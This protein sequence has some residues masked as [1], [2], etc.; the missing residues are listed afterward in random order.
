M[1]PDPFPADQNFFMPAEW[2]T[3]SATWLTW[4]HN[5]ETWPGTDMQAIEAVYL[6]MIRALSEGET[7]HVLLQD[8]AAFNRVHSQLENSRVSI[9]R[10]HCHLIP[11]NDSWI[12]DYGPNFLVRRDTGEVAANVWKFDSWGGKYDWELDD[13]AG[14]TIMRELGLPY[15][16]PG[17][18]LEGGAI[19]VNGQGICL[20][21]EPCLLNPN[22]N[23]GMTREEMERYLSRY[24]GV[25]HVLWCQGNI[26]G[27][28]TDG[29]IDN[30]VRFVS[31]DT[32]LCAWEED[33]ADPNYSCLQANFEILKSFRDAQGRD[34]KVERLPMPGR[35]EGEDGRLPASYANFYIGNSVVLLP[36]YNHDNDRKAASILKKY[37]PEKEIVEIPCALFVRGL[38]GIHCVTQQQ[39][40]GK[41]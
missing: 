1:T 9:S 28:D 16:E 24:L 33:S 14:K 6:R 8:E 32:V 36:V 3:H 26:E 10:V 17:I 37:F 30:L 4:P 27:D 11:T 22:R 21:T 29:H 34:L 23:G 18:V 13:R 35:V 40:R 12:R 5:P 2:E 25:R 7:V 38:G 39:P 15:F 31:P 20:T 19:E 41:Q